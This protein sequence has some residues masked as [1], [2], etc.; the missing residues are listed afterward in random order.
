MKPFWNLCF[1]T[2]S[3]RR[4]L[5]CENVHGFLRAGSPVAG[6]GAGTLK[7]E[8]EAYEKVRVVRVCAEVGRWHHQAHGGVATGA[9]SRPGAAV[10]PG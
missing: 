8:I 10:A 5:P 2:D 4:F 3:R 6:A 7:T 1:K 9:V